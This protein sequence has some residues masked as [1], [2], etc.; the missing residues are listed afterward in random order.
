MRTQV[1]CLA[2]Y[3]RHNIKHCINPGPGQNCSPGRSLECV[4]GYHFKTLKVT[5]TFI[6]EELKQLFIKYDTVLPPSATVE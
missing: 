4:A 2:M 5:V 1:A 6:H 3:S